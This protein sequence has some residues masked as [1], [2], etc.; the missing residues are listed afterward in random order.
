[1]R[2][3]ERT[4]GTWDGDLVGAGA[5]VFMLDGSSCTRDG[6]GIWWVL[7]RVYSCLMAPPVHGMEITILHSLDSS[8]DSFSTL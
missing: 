5:G 6:M 3:S 8:C 7:V 1:M 2:V 4:E